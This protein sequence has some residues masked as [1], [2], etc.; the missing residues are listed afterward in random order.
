MFLPLQPVAV[1]ALPS[2]DDAAVKEYLLSGQ[3]RPE[4]LQAAGGAVRLVAGA[5]AL[6]DVL[7][8][9][10]FVCMHYRWEDGR[11]APCMPADPPP[12]LGGPRTPVAVPVIS[13]GAGRTAAVAAASS[14][15]APGGMPLRAAVSATFPAAAC[16]SAMALG[17]QAW[18]PAPVGAMTAAG[19]PMLSPASACPAVGV[20]TPGTSAQS[21]APGGAS[22][23]WAVL[24]PPHSG[25]RAAPTAPVT[26]L[27][28][29][30]ASAL[31]PAAGRPTA[32]VLAALSP[33]AVPMPLPTAAC[34]VAAAVTLATVDSHLAGGSAGGAAAADFGI[35]GPPGAASRPLVLSVA[36]AGVAVSPVGVSSMAGG[37]LGGL[38][39]GAVGNLG[40]ALG[41][42]A[43]NSAPTPVHGRFVQHFST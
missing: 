27:S 14:P 1:A 9:K 40:G 42:G 29:A 21:L 6:K 26:A 23:L 12:A 11:L 2:R 16:V 37:A 18:P 39:A 31:F 17:P 25:A 19:E 5:D 3:D 43:P 34:P 8:D 4:I 33:A 24:G 32:R 38:P 10:S 28:H 35:V 36:D 13:A 41:V 15:V 20:V 22:P 7:A 30:A